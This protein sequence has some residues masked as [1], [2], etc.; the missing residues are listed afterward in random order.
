MRITDKQ[1][2][3]SVESFFIAKGK[4]LERRE[5]LQNEIK[6]SASYT[7]APLTSRRYKELK[8]PKYNK[9]KMYQ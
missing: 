7:S 3:N 5:I 2:I 9:K 8:R 6:I 1:G 4:L